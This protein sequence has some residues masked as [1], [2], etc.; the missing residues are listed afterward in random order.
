M[1]EIARGIKEIS[2]AV[3]NVLSIAERLGEQGEV[4]NKEL[5]RFKTA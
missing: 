4:L 2:D 3:A 1:G 5:T